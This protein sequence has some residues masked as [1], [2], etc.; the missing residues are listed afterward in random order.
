MLGRT[1]TIALRSTKPRA[2]AGLN[3]LDPKLLPVHGRDAETAVG[4]AT[5]PSKK[6]IADCR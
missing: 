1:P 5:V 4:A 2:P 3:G 6:F